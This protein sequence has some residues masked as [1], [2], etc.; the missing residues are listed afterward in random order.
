MNEIHD[1]SPEAQLNSATGKAPTSNRGA[2]LGLALQATSKGNLH[3]DLP[4]KHFLRR[5]FKKIPR[6][7]LKANLKGRPE[8]ELRKGTC[9]EV[10]GGPRERLKGGLRWGGA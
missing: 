2:I 8:E 10:C 9:R 5:C 3:C 7:A 4:R 6:P 1:F